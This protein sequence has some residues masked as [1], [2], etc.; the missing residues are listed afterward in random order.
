MKAL[1]ASIP[2]LLV[3]GSAYVMQIETVKTA[4]RKRYMVVGNISDVGHLGTSLVE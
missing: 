1:G 2:Q 4:Y 3:A